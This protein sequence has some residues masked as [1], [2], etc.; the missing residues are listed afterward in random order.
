MLLAVPVASLGMTP[1]EKAQIVVVTTVRPRVFRGA[2]GITFADQEGG[3]IRAL[4]NAPPAAAAASYTSSAEAFTAGR[5]TA[6][7]L[8]QAGID[9]GFAPVLD[10]SDGPLGSRQFSRP[11]FGVA[12]ARG[13]GR[14]ACAK[15]FPGLG[16]AGYSTDARPHVDA[17]IR[18]RDLAP[19]RRDSTGPGLRHGR[20]RFLR[21]AVPRITGAV[22]LP[23]ACEV[24]GS[25]GSQSPTPFHLFGPLPLSAGRRRRSG[26]EQT[27]CCSPARRTPAERSAHW[28]RSRV[29]ASSTAA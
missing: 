23:G 10:T 29:A 24:S 5:R 26:P 27:W 7:A 14:A 19:F 13:L 1:L 28:F 11:Q 9:V 3:A 2:S 22:H 17:R 4:P 25:E 8:H 20:T 18:S 6:G 12:F 21:D 16:S 15:H